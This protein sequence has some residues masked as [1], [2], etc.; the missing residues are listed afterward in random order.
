MPVMADA[1]VDARPRRGP[2]P[3]SRGHLFRDGAVPF[4]ERG[5][6]PEVLDLARLA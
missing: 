3:P 1:D 6:E 2:R 5:V 4:D